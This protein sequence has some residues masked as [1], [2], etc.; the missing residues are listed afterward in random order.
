MTQV[1]HISGAKGGAG[2]TTCAVKLGLALAI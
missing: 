2:A 1:I